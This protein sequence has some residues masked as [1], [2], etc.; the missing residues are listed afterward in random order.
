MADL[1]VAAGDRLDL[2]FTVMVNEWN[3][4]NITELRLRDLRVHEPD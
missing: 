2:L 4:N 3:G 1:P